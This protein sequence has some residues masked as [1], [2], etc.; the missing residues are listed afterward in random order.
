MKEIHQFLA[1]MAESSSS[2]AKKS[3]LSKW[4]KN[5]V[6]T[7]LLKYTYDPYKQ[8]GL[9]SKQLKNRPDLHSQESIT[10][11]LFWTCLLTEAIQATRLSPWSMAT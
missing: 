10:S 4:S 3:V 11:G 1:E 5:R 7:H 9:K 6:I 8:Y 2:N